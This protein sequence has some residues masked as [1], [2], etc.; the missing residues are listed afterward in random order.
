MSV[1]DKEYKEAVEFLYNQTPMFQQIGAAAYK[2]G[3]ETVRRLS[4]LFG[5][6]EKS[7]KVIHMGGTNGKGSVSH[8]IAACLQSQGYKVG[9]FTSPHLVD[10]R[11]RIRVDGEMISQNAVVDFVC[12]YKAMTA[13][14]YP[15]FF[16][17]TTIM[18][19]DYFKS[20]H[21]DFA[22]IEVG[23][24]G[25]LD[26]TNIVDPLLD[27]ITNVSFDHTAQLGNTLKS[28]AFEK[29]G[30]MREG[31]PVVCGEPDAEIRAF[32]E[33]NAREKGANIE[34]AQTMP[35]LGR[36][37]RTGGELLVVDTPFGNL[38]FGLTGNC[39]NENA[40]TIIC[41]LQKLQETGIEI[42]DEAVKA[43]FSDVCRL[44]GLRGRW[45]TV[46]SRPLAICDTGH[47]LA[48]IRQ[49]VPFLKRMPRP[50]T[51]VLGFVSDKD[52]DSVLPLFPTDATFIFTQPSVPRRMP[53][54]ILVDKAARHN[55]N[56]LACDSVREAY[57][58]ARRITPASGSIFIGG[59]TFVVADLL[60]YL[61]SLNT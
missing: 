53:V 31:V 12:R 11:E 25:R 10:F 61:N 60:S 4:E 39:Q 2:P 3:L 18:A 42:S 35:G 56:G 33:E 21:V 55:L 17:L 15:S 19:F 24:G 7:L 58:L 26:S 40:L 27:V 49:M 43:G 5:S 20:Q 1:T 44:T 47:N 8:T 29:S 30:I 45:Q 48:G 38:V 36:A 32:F 52:V 37:L 57:N 9:L 22:V 23:L 46:G 16:E 34:F 59:S 41:A 50:L 54:D 6:P 14:L 51:M 28:I 13:D